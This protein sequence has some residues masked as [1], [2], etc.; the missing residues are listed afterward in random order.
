MANENKTSEK[1]K[2]STSFGCFIPL[3]IWWLDFKAGKTH[4]E[5][6]GPDDRQV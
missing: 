1:P 5:S 6:A 2:Y 4:Y 3:D